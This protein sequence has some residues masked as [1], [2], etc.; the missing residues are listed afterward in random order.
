LEDAASLTPGGWTSVSA[1][2]TGTAVRRFDNATDVR[3]QQVF[4]LG[5]R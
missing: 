3:A 5:G 4:S 1:Y 2:A